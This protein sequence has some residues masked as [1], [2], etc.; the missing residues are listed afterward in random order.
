MCKNQNT[1]LLDADKNKN[2]IEALKLPKSVQLLTSE[3]K[4]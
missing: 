2:K 4:S 1:K 3:S